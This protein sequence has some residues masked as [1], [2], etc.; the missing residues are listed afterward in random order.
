[1]LGTVSD[2]KSSEV[3]A[4]LEVEAFY[5]RVL[6]RVT[7]DDR[8]SP[9][10][11]LPM[12]SAL[13]TGFEIKELSSFDYEQ[14]HAAIRKQTTSIEV[15]S[16]ERHW[17]V[18]IDAELISN[19]LVAVPSFPDDDEDAIAAWAAAGFATQRKAERIE[20][21][22]RQQSI[23]RRQVRLKNL[24]TDLIA[25]LTVLEAHAI[26]C[27]RG[28]DWT[29]L[30]AFQALQAIARRTNDAI[31]LGHEAH[32]DK[33]MPPG[34]SIVTGWGGIRTANPDTIA[35]RVQAWFDS[36]LSQNLVAS[37]SRSEYGE[38][39]GV[40]VF[41]HLE[42]ELE[43]VRRDPEHYVPTEPL[44]LP[45]P[46]THVWCILGPIVL[47]YSDVG[48]WERHDRAAGPYSK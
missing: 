20:E 27:T 29:T 7:P 40:L 6:D 44:D 26:Y 8:P 21:W 1:M 3:E 42:P 34:I 25:P 2:E 10:Y 24:L 17:H 43:A 45:A 5:G 11:S 36:D 37:L 30:D 35:E 47:R 19:R 9:D 46:L 15:A 32:P 12:P 28:A 16:L 22:K 18:A 23:P 41:N 31:C 38:R 14:L 33:G 48:G 39:H 13:P 4:R